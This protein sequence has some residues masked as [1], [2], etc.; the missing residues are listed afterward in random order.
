M[1][2]GF[3]YAFSAFPSSLASLR[4]G[5][6]RSR[7]R[8]LCAA[9]R[10]LDGED[11]FRNMERR[12]GAGLSIRPQLSGR[13]AKSA[14]NDRIV[15]IGLYSVDQN[16]PM[17]HLRRTKRC[18]LRLRLKRREAQ[19]RIHVELFKGDRENCRK[20]WVSP[21]PQS[22]SCRKAPR[23]LPVGMPTMGTLAA[24][25]RRIEF[26]GGSQDSVVP[27]ASTVGANATKHLQKRCS[28][29]L[30]VRRPDRMI[31]PFPTP[32]IGGSCTYAGSSGT[33]FRPQE[34]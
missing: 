13:T 19:F 2:E 5:P 7:A 17:A 29:C 10:T 15:V 12:R 33:R 22:Q 28:R 18:K 14:G 3:V 24:F 34:F 21:L 32:S 25:G 26:A 1:G 4:N 30:L 27:Y 31:A 9:K 23:F 11:R 6:Y 16:Q 8:G 20:Q